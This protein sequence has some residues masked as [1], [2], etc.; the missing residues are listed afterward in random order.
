MQV[1]RHGE[2][3]RNADARTNELNVGGA[4][5]EG[6]TVAWQAHLDA[7]AGGQELM[8][9]LRSASTLGF[10]LDRDEVLPPV[11]GGSEQR[12]LSNQGGSTSTGEMH[13]DVRSCRERSK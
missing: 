4:F 6:E 3:R 5:I 11:I 2:Q 12:V 8:G 1:M 13:V 10:S 7:R 9:A